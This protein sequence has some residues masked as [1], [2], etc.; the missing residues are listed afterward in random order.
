MAQLWFRNEQH[1]L[2][3]WGAVTK[4]YT[5]S[6]CPDSTCI[7]ISIHQSTSGGIMNTVLCQCLFPVTVCSIVW[8]TFAGSLFLAGVGGLEETDN[9]RLQ[10]DVYLSL[11]L[12]SVWLHWL[13]HLLKENN[14]VVSLGRAKCPIR[15]I[16]LF[17]FLLSAPPINI[18]TLFS[19]VNLKSSDT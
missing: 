16:F 10:S 12:V 8:N 2:P 14:T 17:I 1:Q 7:D 4:G 18:T 11:Y 5:L 3:L 6:L 15:F 13:F 9:I 19:S